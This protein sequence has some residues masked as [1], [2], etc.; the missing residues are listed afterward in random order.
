VLAQPSRA[1]LSLRTSVVFQGKGGDRR[2]TYCKEWMVD[3]GLL[4]SSESYLL[5]KA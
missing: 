4:I 1:P 3:I 5:E 2:D